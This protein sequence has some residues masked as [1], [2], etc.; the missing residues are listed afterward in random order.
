MKLNFKGSNRY[1][2]DDTMKGIIY[3]GIC[4]NYPIILFIYLYIFKV[5]WGLLKIKLEYKNMH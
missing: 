4:G 2:R 1:S 3:Y 5:Y